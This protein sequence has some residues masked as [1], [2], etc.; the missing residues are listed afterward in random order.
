MFRRQHRYRFKRLLKAKKRENV[1]DEAKALV[2]EAELHPY[3]YK[4]K[5]DSRPAC[6]V[7][8]MLMAEHFEG[9]ANGQD[10]VPTIS[11]TRSFVRTEEQTRLL[12]RLNHEFTLEEVEEGISHLKLNKSEGPDRMRNEHI[13]SARQLL[14]GWITTLFNL[15]LAAAVFPSDWTRCLLAVIYKGKGP[16]PSSPQAGGASARRTFSGSFLL[17]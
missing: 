11:Q 9:I 10:T 15:C 12:S 4:K 14:A 13:K 2:A 3:K 8:P 17:P 5:G 6:P 1:L 7:P 16:P